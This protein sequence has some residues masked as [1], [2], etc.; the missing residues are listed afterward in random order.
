M[1]IVK[2]NTGGPFTV[3]VMLNNASDCWTNGRYWTPNPSPISR[4][5]IY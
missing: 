3:R 2:N 1:L 5:I 4:C